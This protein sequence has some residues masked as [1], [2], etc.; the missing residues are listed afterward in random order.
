MAS[1]VH[2]HGTARGTGH[3][4][5]EVSR[6]GRG[7]PTKSVLGGSTPKGGRN[8][9]SDSLDRKSQ[10]QMGTGRNHQLASALLSECYA[11]LGARAPSSPGAPHLMHQ[12]DLCMCGP[13]PST[14][15]GDAPL[16]EDLSEAELTVFKDQ[17]EAVSKSVIARGTEMH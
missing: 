3:T 15:M 10:R 12:G 7:F 17:R 16:R 9:V 11:M 6:G 5:R 1:N 8:R 14:L 2:V 4:N 13:P